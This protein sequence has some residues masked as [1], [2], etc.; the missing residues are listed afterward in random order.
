MKGTVCSPGMR[1]HIRPRVLMYFL[2]LWV[3]CACFP[4]LRWMRQMSHWL[5]STH[6]T[7]AATRKPLMDWHTARV[8]VDRFSV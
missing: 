5:L 7:G 1:G 6:T 4:L 3:N 2:P 8:A